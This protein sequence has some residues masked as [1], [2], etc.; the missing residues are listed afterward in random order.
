MWW[1]RNDLP[2]MKDEWNQAEIDAEQA[3]ILREAAARQRGV[4]VET[5]EEWGERYK[6]VEDFEKFLR[7]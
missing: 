5:V 7:R 4:Q 6:S 1:N 3:R 2:P